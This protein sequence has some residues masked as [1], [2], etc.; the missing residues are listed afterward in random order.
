MTRILVTIISDGDTKRAD[1]SRK[2]T[3]KMQVTGP[4]SFGRKTWENTS[5]PPPSPSQVDGFCLMRKTRVKTSQACASCRKHK[6]RCEVLDPNGRPVRCHR[7]K[8]LAIECFYEK[9]RVSVASGSSQPAKR[10][11]SSESSE[12]AR[13]RGATM[14]NDRMWGYLMPEAQSL[15]WSAPMIA[16]LQL[17]A[18]GASQFPNQDFELSNV[19]SEDRISYLIDLFDAQYTPWLNFQPIRNSRNPIVDIACSAVAARHLE[20]VHGT[21]VRLRL[22]V[23][24]HESI[25]QMILKSTAGESLEAVQALLILSLWGPFGG[26]QDMGGWDAQSFISAGVRMAISLR[27][28]HASAL[29]VDMHRRA[30][31][32]EVVNVYEVAERARLWV[33]LTNAESMLCMGTGRTPLSRRTLSDHLFTAFPPAFDERTDLRN[34]RLGIAA[35]Q[36]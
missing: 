6:T 35:R 8:V 20:G 5:F 21:E 16:I 22:Q 19:L 4:H 33:A 36:Y 10:S 34:V 11:P 15:D 2:K 27:L 26:S 3:E 7:C 28:D 14:S 32:N 29:L 24:T 18:N 30:S 1:S 25:T 12:A 9:T 31:S 23:L 17:P 13:F